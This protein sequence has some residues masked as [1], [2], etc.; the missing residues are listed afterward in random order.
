VR[1]Q[2]KY[3][4]YR[5]VSPPMTQQEV[6]NWIAEIFEEPP[7]SLTPDTP[8]EDVPMWDSMG[9][10]SLLAGIDEKFSIVL[11]DA[12]IKAMTTVGDI[13]APLRR[14]GKLD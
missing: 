10:L 8:R 12:D 6:L 14:H 9:V 3:D 1:Q 2:R 13:L 4:P 5:N 11:T 7:G